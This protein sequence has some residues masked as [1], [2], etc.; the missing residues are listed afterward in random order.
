M[1]CKLLWKITDILTY[2]KYTQSIIVSRKCVKRFSKLNQNLLSETADLYIEAQH[3]K[4][5]KMLRV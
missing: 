3:S 2:L 1:Q 5:Y 4:L